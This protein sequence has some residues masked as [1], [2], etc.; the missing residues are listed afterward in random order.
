[1]TP[2]R[3]RVLAVCLA[4]SAVIALAGGAAA[5]QAAEPRTVSFGSGSD[6]AT[7]DLNREG[8]NPHLGHAQLVCMNAGSP[9]P[10]PEG[11]TDFGAPF[12]GWFADRSSIP[13]A[14]WIWA[15]GVD[16][17]SSPAEQRS[18]LFT[19]VIKIAGRPTQASLSLAADDFA[20]AWVNGHRVGSVGSV[21]DPNQ[22]GAHN[23]LTTFDITKAVHRGVNIIAIRAQNG[24]ASWS[25]YCTDTCTYAQNPAGVLFGGSVTTG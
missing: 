1:M 22:A 14:E 19:K 2:I 8:V 10:C 24:P 20:E 13:G 7:F 21:V 16:G 17:T 18:F 6:W 12:S 25:P 23:Y 9:Y 11:A 4:V 15:P 3:R 5:V